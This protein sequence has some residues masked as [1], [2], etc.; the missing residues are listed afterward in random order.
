[1]EDKIKKLAKLVGQLSKLA[2]KIIELLTYAT[3]IELSVFQPLPRKR[4]DHRTQST[5][6]EMPAGNVSGYSIPQK[7]GDVNAE[8][9]FSTCLGMHKADW[10]DGV[11]VALL[12]Q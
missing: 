1:M 11:I 10:I 9:D 5:R 3:V 12:Q 7:G 8:S 2:L 6:G 4:E